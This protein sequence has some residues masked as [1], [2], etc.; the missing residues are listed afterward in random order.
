MKLSDWPSSE[1]PREKLLRQGAAYLTDAEL[2]AIF[3]RTGLP[4][5]SVMDVSRSLIKDYISLRKLL[6]ASQEELC[7][8]PGLGPAKYA[9]LQAILEIAK[10]YLATGLNRK[11]QFNR[12]NEV[13]DYLAA[14][15]RPY[16]SEHFGALFLDSQHQLIVFE[17]LFRGTIDGASVHPREV[18]CQALKHNAAAVIFAHNHPSGIAE[19][20]EADRDVTLRL[21]DALALVDIRTLDHMIVGDKEVVSMAERGLI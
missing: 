17:V 21:R 7:R 12:C 2:L 19:P 6:D 1:R 14:Q 11:L 5:Q 9:Q 20:S 4:G 3:L 18:V 8:T 16:R 10:R 13:K 15:L